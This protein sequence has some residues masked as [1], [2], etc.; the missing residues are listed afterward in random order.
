[1]YT[2]AVSD[3]QE[4]LPIYTLRERKQNDR[5]DLLINTIPFVVDENNSEYP[6]FYLFSN[7]WDDYGSKTKFKLLYHEG[8]NNVKEIGY[9]KITD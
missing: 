7:D 5:V 6:Y 8:V 4:D 2:M 3:Y 9:V 1:N